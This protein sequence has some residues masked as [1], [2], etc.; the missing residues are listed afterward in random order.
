M[1]R[2]KTMLLTDVLKEYKKEMGIEN[3]LREV[4]LINS[5]EEI[6]GKAIAR[7]TSKVYL[8]RGVLYIHLTS[9]VV[10][11]ELMMIREVLIQRLNEHAGDEIVKSVVLK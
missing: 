10:R 4:E 3:R 7:R 6:A 9:S 11:N 8:K 5:W 2:K 1:R